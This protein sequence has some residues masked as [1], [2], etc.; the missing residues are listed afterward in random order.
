MSKRRKL[1]LKEALEVL[2][3]FD[4]LTLNEAEDLA[5]E[6]ETDDNYYEAHTDDNSEQD[7]EEKES[8]PSHIYIYK[9]K[10][11]YIW[12]AN[13]KRSGRTPLH[14]IVSKKSGP[15]NDEALAHSLQRA[16][17]LFINDRLITIITTWTNQKIRQ[18]RDRLKSRQG[19][20]Y[21]IE[22][23]EIKVLIRILVFLGSTKVHMNQH[24]V[25]GHIMESANRCA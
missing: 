1:A 5:I 16:F 14:N 12:E 11:N 21:D 20:A 17:E 24:E 6:C 4:D 19:F 15:K 23:I 7:A 9:G 3:D 22:N 18:V 13:P 10:D 8:I 2:E 25:F